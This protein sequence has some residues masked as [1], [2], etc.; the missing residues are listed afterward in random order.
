MV[1]HF[2]LLGYISLLIIHC[3]NPRANTEGFLPEHLD[4]CWD[5]T[6]LE[7]GQQP[8]AMVGQV[9]QGA[10]RA[11]S[12]LHVTSVLHGADNGRHHLRGAH[13]GVTRRLLL[14]QLVHHHGRL[15]HDNLGQ[16]DTAG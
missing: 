10:G 11:A 6:R 4:Q 9:V 2:F 15:V 5:S 8:F 1:C 7:D 12:R 16:R 13:Q 3:R 14:G